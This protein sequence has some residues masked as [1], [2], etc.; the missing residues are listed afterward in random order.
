MYRDLHTILSEAGILDDKVGTTE[1]EE[2]RKRKSVN[3]N[4][5]EKISKKGV[6]SHIYAWDP[7]N[8][9]LKTKKKLELILKS[10]QKP[11][12]PIKQ[13]SLVPEEV[14]HLAFKL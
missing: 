2:I 1:F 12:V 13:I 8:Q 4:V 10:N 7:H 5:L 14:T 6:S 3:P 9:S 11:Q